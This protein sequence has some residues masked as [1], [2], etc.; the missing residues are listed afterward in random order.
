MKTYYFLQLNGMKTGPIQLFDLKKYKL[1]PDTLVWRNDVDHWKSAKEFAELEEFIFLDPPLTPF[2]IRTKDFIEKIKIELPKII[3]AIIIFSILIG[4]FTSNI[5][6]ISW[7]NY[8]A[9]M[10]MQRNIHEKMLEEGNFYKGKGESLISRF[11]ASVERYPDD[12]IF[13]ED[14][15]IRYSQKQMFIFRPFYSIHSNIYLNKEERK[16]QI[17]L[18]FN[19]SLSTLSFLLLSITVFYLLRFFKIAIK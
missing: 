19:L 17:L 12:F 5:A 8:I 15:E 10:E 7:N 11:P 16:N 2:E 1:K 14:N 3:L 6:K 18:I 4:V 13:G 9:K